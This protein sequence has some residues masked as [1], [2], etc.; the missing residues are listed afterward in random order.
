MGMAVAI[1]AGRIATVIK[2]QK[3]FNKRLS[4]YKKFSHISIT[5]GNN[6]T[7]NSWG[8]PHHREGAMEN[9]PTVC[10]A[11][12]NVSKKFPVERKPQTR[13]NQQQSDAEENRRQ[14][15]RGTSGHGDERVAM[16]EGVGRQGD[17]HP[18]SDPQ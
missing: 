6:A 10:L 15:V 2:R 17:S 12:F 9:G 3:S 7:H 8:V 13:R 18:K 16:H 11:P 5:H 14:F 4:P 1:V